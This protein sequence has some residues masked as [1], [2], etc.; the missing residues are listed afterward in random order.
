[1]GAYHDDGIYAVAAKALAEGHG[2]RIV[3]L[4]GAPPQTKYPVLFPWLLSGVWRLHSTF[5]D[6]VPYLRVVPLAAGLGWFYVS[7]LVMTRGARASGAMPR[8]GAGV[9]LLIT[10][11]SPWV[12]FLSTSIMSETLFALLMTATIIAMRTTVDQEAP[13]KQAWL[14]GALAG[15]S[16][17]TRATGLSVIVAG[18]LCLASRRRR[19]D[20]VRFVTAAMVVGGPWA[21]WVLWQSGAA[22]PA[23]EFYRATNYGAWNVL[24]SYDLTEKIRV[25]WTNALLMATA[26][27]SLLGLPL[28]GATVAPAIMAALLVVRGL[29][30]RR[31]HVVAPFVAVYL[32]MV[33]GWA[34]PPLRFIAPLLPLLGWLAW[35]ALPQRRLWVQSAIATAFVLVS[36]LGAW[37]M[38]AAIRSRGA[39][40]PVMPVRDQWTQSAALLDWIREQTPPESVIAGNL[41]PMY[42]LYT[43]RQAIRAYDTDALRLYYSA[44]APSQPIGTLE[45]LRLR[46]LTHRVAFLVVSPDSGFGETPHFLKLVDELARSR[47]GCLVVAAGDPVSGYVVYRVDRLKLGAAAVRPGLP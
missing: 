38:P 25:L 1:M 39:S 17:L 47:P 27:A 43:G 16:L 42:Y 19:T 8:L 45:T 2:Y 4:P 36:G 9:V 34:W 29:W 31:H 3:S 13:S 32:V 22:Q 15:L 5:P 46:L 20:M 7:W 23:D 30:I 18:V 37:G 11:A 6:N 41:D 21:V 44:G 35:S 33:W 40:W 12:L 28:R 26:P 10:A 24:T 14:A